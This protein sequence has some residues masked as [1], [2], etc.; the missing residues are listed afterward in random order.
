MEKISIVRNLISDTNLMGD[1]DYI[2]VNSY[3]HGGGG[4]ICSSRA[5]KQ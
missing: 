2:M 1:K 3:T 5:L 4:D